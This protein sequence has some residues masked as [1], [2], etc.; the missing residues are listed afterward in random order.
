MT[1]ATDAAAA[2]SINVLELTRAMRR[3]WRPLVLC[4]LIG[5]AAGALILRYAPRRFASSASII[6]RSSPTSGASSMIAQL[7]LGSAAPIIGGAAPLETEL[8]ILTSRALIAPIVD[9]LELGATITSPRSMAARNVI[10]QMRLA[11]AFKPARYTFE[12]IDGGKY[13]ISGSDKDVVAA[14]GA[15]AVL[16]QGTIVLRADTALPPRFTVRLLDHEDAIT[17]A[18]THLSATRT[19]GSEVVTVAFQAPDSVTAAVVPNALVADYLVRRHTVDRGTN[20]H[21]VAFLNDQIDTVGRQLAAAEDSLRRFQERSGVLQP[22]V[23][24]KL[25]LDEAADIRKNM[26]ALDIERGALAQLTSQ[27]ASHQL[28][29]RQLAAYPTFLKSPAMNDLL[30]QLVKVESDRNQLLE[31]RLETDPEVAVLTENARNI[32]NQIAGYAVGYRTSIDRQRHDLTAQLDTISKALGSFPGSVESSGR[33]Q[34]HAKE[35]AQTYAVL[36]AQLVDSRLASIGEGGDVKLLDAATPPKKVVFPRISTTI[37]VG[38]AAGLFV[39]AL[40]ALFSGLLGRYVEDPQ[41]IERATGVPALRMDNSSPLLVGRGPLSST[42]LLVPVN[43]RAST[44]GVAARLARTA[45]AR[46]I[47]PTVLDLSRNGSTPSHALTTDVNATIRRLESEHGMVIVQLPALSADET[48]AALHPDRA[49]LLVV[50]PGRVERK[51]LVDAMATLKRLDVPCAGVVV[52][53]ATD[54]APA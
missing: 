9:S 34:R 47:E 43:D 42:L 3:G 33:L 18:L 52:N 30:A 35:L 11:S 39:G 41:A 23:Q 21:R 17:D 37:G 20:E 28:T 24:G 53:R 10:K 15:P 7:G 38:T 16:P 45:M 50:P 13:R 26:A 36:Q 27:I 6:V 54:A 5:A 25:Q 4:T 40:L 1:H 44:A 2:D 49:V 31:R 51:A 12:K 29:P 32:E 19:T 22:D 8:S 14:A 48:A 46:A